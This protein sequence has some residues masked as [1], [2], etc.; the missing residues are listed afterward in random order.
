MVATDVSNWQDYRSLSAIREWSLIPVL[1]WLYLRG[2]QM[3]YC[4]TNEAYGAVRSC[5]HPYHFWYNRI[6]SPFRRPLRF[7]QHIKTYCH[8]K[9]YDSMLF[10]RCLCWLRWTYPPIW[11]GTTCGQRSCVVGRVG[12]YPT[13]IDLWGRCSAVELTALIKCLS[14]PG[15]QP[16]VKLDLYKKW[17]V[18]Q[19]PARWLR[20]HELNVWIPES[21]SGAL[22]LGYRASYIRLTVDL[23][24][25]CVMIYKCALHKII[26]RSLK[27]FCL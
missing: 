18:W 17:R 23:H 11:H 21:K 12:A 5:R 8:P 20:G 10:A 2:R 9:W 26:F 24:H 3:Y 25:G 1:P 19:C 15:C 14:I 7:T 27:P 4:Y 13:T 22:P 6:S 16:T